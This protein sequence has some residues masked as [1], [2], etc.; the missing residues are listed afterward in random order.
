[1]KQN[2]NEELTWG[3]TWG[4]ACIRLLGA[5]GGGHTSWLPTSVDSRVRFLT[6]PAERN[7]SS[8]KAVTWLHVKAL[9]AAH[10]GNKRILYCKTVKKEHKAMMFNNTCVPTVCLFV[11]VSASWTSARCFKTS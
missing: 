8:P 9:N 1:M 7:S 3:F 2:E 5:Y 11:Y 6:S 4:R 10:S